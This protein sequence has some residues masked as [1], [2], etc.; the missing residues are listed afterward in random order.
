MFLNVMKKA[1]GRFKMRGTEEKDIKFIKKIELD[2]LTHIVNSDAA[3]F[4]K[5]LEKNKNVKELKKKKSQEF[6]NPLSRIL[7][8]KMAYKV[9]VRYA[10]DMMKNEV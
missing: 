3:K 1:F 6:V 5:F 10:R 7:F 4:G 8:A 2:T 9:W